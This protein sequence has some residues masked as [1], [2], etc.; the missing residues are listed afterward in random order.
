MATAASLL[1]HQRSVEMEWMTIAM[2]PSQKDARVPI[3]DVVDQEQCNP[4][5][6]SA[7]LLVTKW[8]IEFASPVAAMM[9][10]R[11][12]TPFHSAMVRQYHLEQD[13]V[14]S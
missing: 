7:A 8:Y 12:H 9:E 10:R 4:D 13:A 2:D 5:D 3:K 14:P 1:E 6:P 11:A